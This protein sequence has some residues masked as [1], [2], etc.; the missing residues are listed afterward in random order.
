M[1]NIITINKFFKA[2]LSSIVATSIDFSVTFILTSIIGC[3][4][5][6]SSASGALIGGCV[7]FLLGRYWVF[8]SVN[9]RK[10]NQA[11]K[12]ILVW[13]LSFMLN[14]LGVYFFTDIVKM[15]YMMSKTIVAVLVSVCF[16]YYLQYNFV[17]SNNENN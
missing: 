11:L 8:K 7:N 4:Y 10:L 9:Q 17:F 13:V 2:Q 15:H 16:N 6:F 14:T 3:W 12:Y 5:L 1:I